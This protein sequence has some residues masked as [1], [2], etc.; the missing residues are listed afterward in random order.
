MTTAIEMMGHPEQPKVKQRPRARVDSLTE[1]PTD[2]ITLSPAFLEALSKVAPKARPPRLP[3]ILTFA[4]VLSIGI[5]SGR[6]ILGH[7]HAAAGAVDPPPAAS[8]ATTP[9][10]VASV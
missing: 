1:M 7:H 2:L 4:T 8:A 3:Y 9:G 10:T 5:A 6:R